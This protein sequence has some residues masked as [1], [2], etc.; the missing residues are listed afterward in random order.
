MNSG[1]L[2]VIV[3]CCCR[4]KMMLIVFSWRGATT[5]CVSSIYNFSVKFQ[6]SSVYSSYIYMSTIAK[7]ATRRK[8]S[9]ATDDR[10]RLLRLRLS[11]I[12]CN[13]LIFLWDGNIELMFI[14][15]SVCFCIESYCSWFEN[16]W[17]IDWLIV[18]H[19][20]LSRLVDCL[21]WSW[22]SNWLKER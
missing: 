15:A 12:R 17:S 13:V 8:I 19:C 10:S 7:L 6:C 11:K 18:S 14:F 1:F 2:D 16:S 4:H 20:A 3:S 21:F 5:V 22:M 9:A